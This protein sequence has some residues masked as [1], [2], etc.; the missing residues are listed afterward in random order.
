[1]GNLNFDK[2]L[3]EAVDNGLLSLGENPRKAIYF[4]LKNGFQLRR[5]HIPKETN[6]FSQALNAIFGPGAK[7]IEKY[8]LKELYQR[9]ELDF[10]EKEDSTFADYVKEAKKLARRK[11]QS[12][13]K[14]TSLNAIG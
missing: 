9:L 2:N 13:A 8:I 1:M 6:E 11:E 5:E 4:H 7:I 12:S 14:S 10:E 3:L